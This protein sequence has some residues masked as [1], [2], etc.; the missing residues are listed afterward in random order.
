MQAY[1]RKGLPPVPGDSKFVADA[2]RQVERKKRLLNPSI[3][4]GTWLL[5]AQ[6]SVVSMHGFF[7][8]VCNFQDI[9]QCLEMKNIHSFGPSLPLPLVTSFDVIMLTRNAAEI[10]QG[11]NM[12]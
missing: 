10:G 2:N 4:G 9:G 7:L 5:H 1:S 11:G 12:S 3:V 6:A 8:G